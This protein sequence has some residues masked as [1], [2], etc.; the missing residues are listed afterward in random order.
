MAHVAQGYEIWRDSVELGFFTFGEDGNVEVSSVTP[1]QVDEVMMRLV[2]A[3]YFKP[4]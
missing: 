1:Y 2:A 4:L 3:E